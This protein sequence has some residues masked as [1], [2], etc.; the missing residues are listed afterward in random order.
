MLF[1]L[2]DD[3]AMQA[4]GGALSEQLKAPAIVYLNGNLGAGK[5]TLVRGFLR[6]LGHTGAVKSPTYTIVESYP[7]AV[8]ECFHFDLYRM[9]DAEELE[10]MGIRDYMHD[11][12]ICMIEWPEL[13]EGV[14]PEP[15]IIID[16]KILDIGRE[17]QV[18]VVNPEFQQSIDKLYI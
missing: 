14:L 17:L 18:Q 5:T 10:A 6:G 16:I 3:E 7:F 1:T 8:Q 15:D 13:G 2:L 12:A 4:W 11:K 9:A